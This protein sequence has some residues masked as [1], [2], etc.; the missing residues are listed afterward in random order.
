M[1]STAEDMQEL[2]RSLFLLRKGY[3]IQKAAVSLF[4]DWLAGWL[5]GKLSALGQ[6]QTERIQKL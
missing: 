4:V 2:D 6:W 5:V 3:L 1:F